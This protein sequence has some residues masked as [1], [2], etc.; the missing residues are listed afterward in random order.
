MEPEGSLPHSQELFICPYP[1]PPHPLSPRFI[2]ILSKYIYIYIYIYMTP[3]IATLCLFYF[4]PSFSFSLL[5]TCLILSTAYILGL[6][7]GL[8]PSGFPTYN[9]YAFLFSPISATWPAHLILL[10]LI[11]LIILGKEFKSRSS[12]LCSFLHSPVT[13]SLFGPNTLSLC[14]SLNVRDQVLHPYTEP[15][16]KL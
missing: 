4:T 3:A 7:S 5:T 15:Q 10:Y 6:H 12:S 8:L 16:A 13:L 11:I 2:L 9:L 1:E 14:S